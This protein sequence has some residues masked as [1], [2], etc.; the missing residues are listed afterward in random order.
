M[1]LQGNYYA[2]A[3][4]TN[5]DGLDNKLK[6]LA[7]QADKRRHKLMDNSAFLQFNWKAN[8]V[9]SWIGKDDM[10]LLWTIVSYFVRD[11]GIWSGSL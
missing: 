7:A 4:R 6:E 3:I 11:L 8:V 5:L 9:E 1:T 10:I 2:D